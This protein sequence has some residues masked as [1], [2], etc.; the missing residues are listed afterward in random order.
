MHLIR[1]ELQQLQEQAGEIIDKSD[2]HKKNQLEKRET[3]PKEIGAAGGKFVRIQS[4]N[5]DIIMNILIG[6]RR[7][8]SSLTDIPGKA[9]DDHEYAKQLV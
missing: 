2:T 8:I 3:Q 9:I 6:I 4:Q 1:Q 5:F 7:S